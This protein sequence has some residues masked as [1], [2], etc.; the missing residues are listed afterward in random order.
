MKERGSASMAICGTPF[1]SDSRVL[2]GEQELRDGL[3]KDGEENQS[4]LH[5]PQHLNST[6][7]STTFPGAGGPS[8]LAGS[9]TFC[10]SDDAHWRAVMKVEPPDS[11]RAAR[12]VLAD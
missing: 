7:D 4:T 9:R 6:L 10:V 8:A 12:A 3:K 5:E 1:S 11:T 2:K